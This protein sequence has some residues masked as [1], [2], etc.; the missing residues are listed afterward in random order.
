LYALGELRL[1]HV[2]PAQLT[3]PPANSLP[4]NL[5]FITPVLPIFL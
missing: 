4:V 5:V 3:D 2:E 1:R